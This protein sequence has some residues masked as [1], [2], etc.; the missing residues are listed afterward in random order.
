MKK[1]EQKQFTCHRFGFEFRIIIHGTTT[2]AIIKSHK[3]EIVDKPYIGVAVLD[4][5]D[6]YNFRVGKTIA[7]KLAVAKY[8]SD[9]F[10]KRLKALY[11]FQRRMVEFNDI[12][13]QELDVLLPDWKVA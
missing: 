3:T 7:M 1:T 8:H 9:N 11:G 10:G 5:S 12:L 4:P 6:E 13:G 2:R